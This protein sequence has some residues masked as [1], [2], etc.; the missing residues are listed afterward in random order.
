MIVEDD[1]VTQAQLRNLLNGNG[2]E[3]ETINNFLVDMEQVKSF[4]PHLILLDI[5]LPGNDGFSVCSQIRVFSNVPIILS[6]AAIQT[7][8]N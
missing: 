8:M 7:W 6:Q 2:Y 1:V 4:Q 5:K 3:N